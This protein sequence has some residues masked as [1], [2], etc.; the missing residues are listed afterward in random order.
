MEDFV[1]EV[2]ASDGIISGR[3][4][5][6]NGEPAPDLFVA[7]KL[8]SGFGGDMALPW[9]SDVAPELPAVTDPDGRFELTGLRPGTYELTARATDGE[10]V[11]DPVRVA[12]GGEATI[13]LSAAGKI[14]G[15]VTGA[16][17]H[18]TIAARGRVHRAVTVAG[19]TCAFELGRLP[20]G[21]YRIIA[22]SAGASASVEVVVKPGDTAQLSLDLQPVGAIRGRLVDGDGRPVAGS[23]LLLVG[24]QSDLTAVAARVAGGLLPRSGADGRFVLE[25]VSPG[26]YVFAPFANDRIAPLAKVPVE[27]SAAETLDLG[28]IEV[29]RDGD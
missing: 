19:P 20:G 22:E 7:A 5:D 17:A 26:S 24:E 11:S 2:R 6:A 14:A 23:P 8:V 25:S 10:A 21:S 9:T 27:V 28:D 16:R 18:C 4:V 3:A 13:K 12:T 1:F 29:A 15:K